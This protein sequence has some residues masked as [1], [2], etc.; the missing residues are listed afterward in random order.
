MTEN[1]ETIEYNTK[2]TILVVDDDY[3]NLKMLSLCFKDSGYRVLAAQNGDSAIKKATLSNPDLILMDVIMPKTD[4]YEVCRRL[5]EVNKLKDTPVIFMTSLTDADSMIKGFEMGGVDYITKPFKFE[6]VIARVSTH[7][8]IQNQRKQIEESATEVATYNEELIAL[9]EELIALNDNLNNS[10]EELSK[11]VKERKKVEDELKKANIEISESLEEL[12]FMQT[13]LV[14][15]EKMAALGNLVAGLAHEINTPIGVAITASTYLEEIS[16]KISYD[17]TDTQKYNEDI[18]E[19]SS[20]ISKNLLKAG[21]L[22][23]NFKLIST[24]QSSEE[25]RRFNLHEYLDEIL[26][27]LKPYTSKEN[28]TIKVICDEGLIINSYPGAFAQIITNF[29]HNSFLHAFEPKES[30]EITIQIAYDDDS[31]TLTYE[32]NGKGMDQRILSKIFD[33]FFTTKRNKGGTGLGMYLVYN[34]VSQQLGGTIKCWSEQ[35]VGT[36]FTINMMTE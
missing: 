30:G 9:N 11:E 26:L 34:I 18:K 33:P 15:T 4:G 10:N 17:G 27:T 24:D 5:K 14:Q 8:R 23:R 25:K 35:D 28:H 31:L 2:N 16:D 29:I 13:F 20:I 36:M 3:E 22:I 32:D 6:E 21:K 1:G 19:A 12:E 7:M